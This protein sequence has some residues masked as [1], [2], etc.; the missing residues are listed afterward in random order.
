VA[1]LF[2]LSYVGGIAAG[3][4]TGWALVQLRRRVEAPLP[5]TTVTVVLPFAAYLLGEAIKGS[6]V[7]AVVVAGLVMSQMG[8]REGPAG[9]R[10]LSGAF[11]TFSTY[12]LNGALF[13]LVGLQLQAAVRGLS[14]T[15]LARGLLAVA[16]VSATL[17]LARLGF[18]FFSA[19]LLRALD[20]RPQQRDL[21]ISNP[22]RLVGGLSGF[23]GAISLA[24]ALSVP[25]VLD[26]GAPFPD[27]DLIIFITSGVIVVTLVVQGL[28]LPALIR[29]VVLPEDTDVEAELRLA[30]RSSV[31]EALA[32]LPQ[33]SAELGTAP[34][35]SNWLRQEYQVYL[36][37]RRAEEAANESHPVLHL[38]RQD[39][40]LRRALLDRKRAT[41]LRLR[42]QEVIDD[43]VLR[44]VQGALDVE[45]VGLE[46]LEFE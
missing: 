34:E 8:P 46:G 42:D 16:L 14:S 10:L 45:E 43:I 6:G 32:A 3:A 12:L 9:T 39:R 38:Y 30:E 5:A 28:A 21:R 24:V 7:L 33:L 11:W 37:V 31:E 41:V 26:S 15:G 29:W 18:M 27:R 23:R 35:V 13:V 17:V 2:V 19:Y 1:G 36:K 22:A 40:Q 4:V 20:R 44:R 25:I